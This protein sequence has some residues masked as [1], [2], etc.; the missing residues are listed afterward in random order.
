ME[1]KQN[2]NRLFNE[3]VA[4]AKLKSD[5]Q[6]SR[7]LGVPPSQICNLRGQRVKLGPAVIVRIMEAHP[8]SLRRIRELL[9]PEA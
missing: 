8:I 7:Y 6:L 3:I 2:V 5:A 4:E 9:E 1:S